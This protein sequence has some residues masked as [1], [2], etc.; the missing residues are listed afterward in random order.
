MEYRS[1]YFGK[2]SRGLKLQQDIFPMAIMYRPARRAYGY[3]AMSRCLSEGS[4]GGPRC[5]DLSGSPSNIEPGRLTVK[6]FNA[7]LAILHCWEEVLK[8]SVEYCTWTRV[9]VL[10]GRSRTMSPCWALLDS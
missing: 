2:V 5:V 10:L 9:A 6:V 8:S 4:G 1:A 7:L 3:V